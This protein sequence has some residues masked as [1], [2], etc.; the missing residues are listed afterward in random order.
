MSRAYGEPHT[1][2]SLALAILGVVAPVVAAVLFGL[3]AW[4]IEE[5]RLTLHDLWCA[6]MLSAL[7][8]FLRMLWKL[9]CWILEDRTGWGL[10]DGPASLSFALLWMSGILFSFFMTSLLWPANLLLAALMPMKRPKVVVE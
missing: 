3:A 10:P 1:W 6:Y 7:F 2:Q 9:P 4:W 5:G 8:L